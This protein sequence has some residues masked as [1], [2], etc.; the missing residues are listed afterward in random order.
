MEVIVTMEP[1]KEPPSNL[2]RAAITIKRW[3][4]D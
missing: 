2:Q 3:K 4:Q 1:K